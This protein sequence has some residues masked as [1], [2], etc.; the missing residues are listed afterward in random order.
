[1]EFWLRRSTKKG[2][3]VLFFFFLFFDLF[4]LFS[5]LSPPRGERMH[6]QFSVGMAAF[7][8][9]SHMYFSCQNF[10]FHRSAM[11]YFFSLVTIYVMC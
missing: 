2:I 5:P 3:G 1:M 4:C 8:L 6:R 9:P 10:L 11:C 7:S